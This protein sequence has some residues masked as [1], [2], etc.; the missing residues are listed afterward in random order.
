MERWEQ[1]EIWSIASGGSRWE[2]VAAFHDFDVASAVARR[3]GQNL[4]LVHAI[5]VDGKLAEQ[6]V[7]VELGKTRQTA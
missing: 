7:L 2:F 6:Q 3:R 5:Y 1:Y 4:R